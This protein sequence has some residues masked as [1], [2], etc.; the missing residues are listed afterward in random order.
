MKRVLLGVGNVLSH[1]DGVGP[2]VAQ[3]L[4]GDPSWLAIDVRTALENVCGIVKREAPDLLVIVDAARMRRSPGC[5]CR[6]PIQARDTMLAST[7]GL[8]ISFVWERLAASAAVKRTVL[9]GV[10]PGNL[11]FGEGLSPAVSAAAEKLV[12][13]LRALDLDGIPEWS[14]L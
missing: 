2:H 10:E 7:H 14:C 9:I 6:L 13:C 12:A 1:D 4:V 3:A 11:S 5:V 8:P